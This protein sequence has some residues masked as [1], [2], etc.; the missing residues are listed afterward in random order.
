MTHTIL[1]YSKCFPALRSAPAAAGCLPTRRCGLSL[2]RQGCR[3]SFNPIF[4]HSLP[5]FAEGL[6]LGM[7]FWQ[8]NGLQAGE[9]EKKQIQTLGCLRSQENV[10][11]P[12]SP[13]CLTAPVILPA[14]LCVPLSWMHVMHVRTHRDVCESLSQTYL[15]S[16]RNEQG[17]VY[18]ELEDSQGKGGPDAPEPS[19]LL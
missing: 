17:Q 12:V 4:E 6:S 10:G 3:G 8:G 1:L 9:L 5:V 11:C 18:T 15:Q 16:Q 2:Q 14:S 13:L 19:F 7:G